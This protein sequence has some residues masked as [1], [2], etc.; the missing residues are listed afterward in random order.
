MHMLIYGLD[1]N[2][3]EHLEKVMVLN[4]QL[5]YRITRNLCWHILG[6]ILLFFAPVI[7]SVNS[8]D[9]SRII[10][11][12]CQLLSKLRRMIPKLST[13]LVCFIPSMQNVLKLVSI[14]LQLQSMCTYSIGATEHFSQ[15]CSQNQRGPAETFRNEVLYRDSY[16]AISFEQRTPKKGLLLLELCCALC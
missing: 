11:E 3:N 10:F 4:L 12:F 9:L 1:G 7:H 14:P 15:G 13:A 2:S 16:P 8:V 5:N 6:L